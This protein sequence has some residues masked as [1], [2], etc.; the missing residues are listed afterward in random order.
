MKRTWISLLLAVS[1]L[2]CCLFGAQAEELQGKSGM[3]VTF[4]GSSI[5]ANYKTSD[6]TKSAVEMMPG[7]SL[8]YEIAL[9][10]SADFTASWYMSNAVRRSMEENSAAR[11]G[12]Y[13]YDLRFI[14]SDGKET[15]IYDSSSVGGEGLQEVTENL[16]GNKLDNYFFLGNVS[17]GQSGTVRLTIALDGET[18]GN[19]YQDTLADLRMNFAASRS[20]SGS[21]GSGSPGSGTGN[22]HDSP[23]T[24]NSSNNSRSGGN[25]RSGR[26]TRPVKTGDETQLYPYYIAAGVSGLLLLFLFFFRRKK[27]EEEEEKEGEA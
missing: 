18:Q 27:E 3:K 17:S 26:S 5:K 9:A 16:G 10:N 2:T 15:V 8:S 19:D 1:L 13:T 6:L 4:N 12:A 22:N 23:G 14:A 21:D 20:N 7:D 25:G 11:G 24:G